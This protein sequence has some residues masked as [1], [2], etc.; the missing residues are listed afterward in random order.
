MTTKKFKI[1]DTLSGVGSVYKSENLIANVQYELQIGQEFI[2]SRSSS[3]EDEIP[4]FKRITGLLNIIDGEKNLIGRDILTLQLSDGRKWSFFATNYDSYSG[5][6]SL[7]NA[8]GE[9]LTI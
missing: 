8:P 4:S 6:F 2:I 9:Q 7:V 1:L 5:T 3:G